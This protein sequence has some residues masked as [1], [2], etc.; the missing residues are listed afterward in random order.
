[1]IA[2]FQGWLL[3]LNKKHSKSIALLKHRKVAAKLKNYLL[4]SILFRSLSCIFLSSFLPTQGVCPVPRRHPTC[5]SSRV[6]I[7]KYLQLKHADSPALAGLTRLFGTK[8]TT[9]TTGMTGMQYMTGMTEITVSY[10]QSLGLPLRSLSPP[11]SPE[12]LKQK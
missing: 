1:M 6:H 5:R 12:F 4:Q 7:G 9:H 11:F 3:F 10:L 2:Y 8:G